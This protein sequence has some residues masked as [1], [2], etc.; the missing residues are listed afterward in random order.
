MEIRAALQYGDRSQTEP[1]TGKGSST[2]ILNCYLRHKEIAKLERAL[3]YGATD[4]LSSQV[5]VRNQ[6][7]VWIP[8]PHPPPRSG[9][10]HKQPGKVP[11]EAAGAADAQPG[12]ALS[13]PREGPAL[14]R[15]PRVVC[16]CSK[17]PS[18]PLC[19]AHTLCFILETRSLLGW[20][21]SKLTAPW[22]AARLPGL[23]SAISGVP[24]LC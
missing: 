4:P 8:P 18:L 5:W 17:S 20:S 16:A 11:C 2:F 12:P 6:R 9:R 7:P 22:S 13:K 21:T 14:P 15:A 23:G 19:R 1:F 10:W 24:E 3:R